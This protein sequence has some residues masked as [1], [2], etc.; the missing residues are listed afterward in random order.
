MDYNTNK[1][2]NT[3]LAG[4]SFKFASGFLLLS[5]SLHEVFLSVNRGDTFYFSRQT[6][7]S[8]VELYFAVVLG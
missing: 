2:E 7:L 3:R 5:Q 4:F 8:S 1:L 6:P